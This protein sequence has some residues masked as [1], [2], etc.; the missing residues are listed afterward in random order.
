MKG[1]TTTPARNASLLGSQSMTTLNTTTPFTKYS[2]ATFVL[3]GLQIPLK[4]PFL[5][6]WTSTNMHAPTVPSNVPTNM[7]SR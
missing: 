5:F 4:Y 7:I 3:F 1:N 2:K 6:R